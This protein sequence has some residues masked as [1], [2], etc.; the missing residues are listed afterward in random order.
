MDTRSQPRTPAGVPSG[1]EFVG[2]DRAEASITLGE[3]GLALNADDA[4]AVLAHLERLTDQAREAAIAADLHEVYPDAVR[5]LFAYDQVC[6]ST[7]VVQLFDAAGRE[8]VRPGDMD[9]THPAVM[10]ADDHASQLPQAKRRTGFELTLGAAGAAHREAMTTTATDVDIVLRARQFELDH[11][12]RPSHVQVDAAVAEAG[13]ALSLSRASDQ[14]EARAGVMEVGDDVAVRIAAEYPENLTLA[15][16]AR[17]ERVSLAMLFAESTVEYP[18]V[19]SRRQQ[20][21][22]SALM[23]YAIYGADVDHSSRMAGH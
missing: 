10:R 23:T 5:A 18:K 21:R 16:F 1:G 4:A 11:P 19:Y 7:N 8:L 3:I 15:A 9:S 12:E 2:H 17:G 13:R 14:C 20:E 6:A 22:L